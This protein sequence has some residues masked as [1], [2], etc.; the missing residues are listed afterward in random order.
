MALDGGPWAWAWVRVRVRVLPTLV[1][2]PHPS[3]RTLWPLVLFSAA[4]RLQA[5]V[6][7]IPSARM[8]KTARDIILVRLLW[9]VR[10]YV[11]NPRDMSIQ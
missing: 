9:T 1:P 4:G 6:L 11:S 8:Q 2:L 7:S 5:A 3:G 10:R